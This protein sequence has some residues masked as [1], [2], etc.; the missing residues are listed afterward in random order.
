[1]TAAHHLAMRERREGAVVLLSPA[2]ASWDQFANFE[3][4]GEVFRRLVETLPGRR[5]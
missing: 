5:A 3:E 2:G 4:R 1:V